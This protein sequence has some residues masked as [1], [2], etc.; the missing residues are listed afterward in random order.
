MVESV[1]PAVVRIN[2]GKLVGSGFIFQRGYG[3]GAYVLTNYHV[4]DRSIVTVT[5]NDRDRYD[6]TVLGVDTVRDVAVLRICCGEFSTV[7]FA[8]E[9]DIK[10]GIEVA[11][12]GY[13]LGIRGEATV[14]RGI[15]SAVRYSDL[16]EITVIQTDAAINPG[17]S[18]GPMFSM[19]GEVVG[20]N[21]FGLRGLGLEG[22]SFALSIADVN[23]LLPSLLSAQTREVQEQA[24]FWFCQ[25]ASQRLY[26]EQIKDLLGEVEKTDNAIEALIQRLASDP[27]LRSDS[28]WRTEFQGL[29][30]LMSQE[31][32]IIPVLH[33]PT[34]SL[35]FIQSRM[36]ALIHLRE[37]FA[38]AFQAF[39]DDHNREKLEASTAT[40]KR[41]VEVRSVEIPGLLDDFC[42]RAD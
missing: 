2:S 9:S 36:V 19:D 7:A 13:A 27:G 22:L 41:V 6:G 5:V 40:W 29:R 38:A 25:T 16:H 26:I 35:N 8:D 10:A 33:P 30:S 21:A 3:G 32:V 28:G 11:A 15:V 14:S 37:E 4:L 39:I 17:N 42:D 34:E 12:I 24:N 23:A 31:S 1:R 18:G 20:I